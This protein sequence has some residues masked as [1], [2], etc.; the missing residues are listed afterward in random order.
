M[1]LELHCA[2]SI[3]LWRNASVSRL[4]VRG[5]GRA[6]LVILVI[7]IGVPVEH[8]RAWHHGEREG[9]DVH[10]HSRHGEQ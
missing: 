2:Q 4:W 9:V 5:V 10:A 7:M 3:L 6:F 8:P 1:F